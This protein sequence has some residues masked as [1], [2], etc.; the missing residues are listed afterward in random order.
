MFAPCFRL[1]LPLGFALTSSAALAIDNA[2]VAR[3][4]AQTLVVSWQASDPVSVFVA[5][6][7]DAAPESATAVASDHR[8]YGGVEGYLQQE[9][10]IGASEIAR[11]RALNLE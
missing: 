8:D 11:L 9:L 7:P 5:T 1:L 4:D 2:V 10:G 6:S 3:K